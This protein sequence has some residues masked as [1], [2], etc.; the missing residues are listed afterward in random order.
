MGA[1]AVDNGQTEAAL[2]MGF[3]ERQT[4]LRI[5]FPQSI[6]HFLPAYRSEVITLVKATA[7]VGYIAVQDL[8]KV[9]DLIRSRT[10]EAFFP[11]IAT[12]IIYY[13]LTFVLTGIVRRINIVTDP[14][15]RSE[16]KIFRGIKTK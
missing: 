11:L 6:K 4:Y 5:I 8:T 1:G 13:L 2:A 9:S 12:A 15:R 10:Y 3:S 7:I 14:R 16:K